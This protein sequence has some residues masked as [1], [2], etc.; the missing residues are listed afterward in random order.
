M[1]QHGLSDEISEMLRCP[2]TQQPLHFATGSELLDF[3]AEFPEGAYITRD[4]KRVYP[5]ENGF[6]ILVPERASTSSS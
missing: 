4:L 3:E 1:N 2:V 6:L 5:V